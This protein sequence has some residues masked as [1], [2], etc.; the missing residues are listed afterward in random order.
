MKA[1][2]VGAS[3]SVALA[4]FPAQ[5]MA[6]CGAPSVAVD[7]PAALTALLS[8][9][10]VC[11]PAVTVPTM[12]WQEFHQPG[13]ALIDYKRGPGNAMDP[14]E[15]VGSWRISGNSG[16]AGNEAFITHDYGA[17]GSYTYKVYNN[18]TTISFCGGNPSEIVASVR[19]G[20]VACFP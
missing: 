18:G 11:V 15:T 12:Q 19:S 4:G 16:S 8:N 6:A 13:G 5:A 14:T 1:L 20:Q 7:T 10:T 17:G 3:I 2:I 9:K